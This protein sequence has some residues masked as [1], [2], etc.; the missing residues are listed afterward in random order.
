M[1]NKWIKKYWWLFLLGFIL[2]IALAF[3]ITLTR[4]NPFSETILSFFNDWSIPL[5]AL[6]T[7]IL[8]AVAFWA[9]RENRLLREEDRLHDLHRFALDKVYLWIKRLPDF[10]FKMH[11]PHNILETYGLIEEVAS[12]RFQL[13]EVKKYANM[14]EEYFGDLFNITEESLNEYAKTIND[15]LDEIR[16]LPESEQE[17]IFL[18][19]SLAM[20][21][22]TE[23]R[24]INIS[25]NAI[26]KNIAD[27]R[28]QLKL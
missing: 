7:V 15:K 18:D 4:T 12:L 25:S 2:I 27:I 13:L 9:I 24:T 26:L 21:W 20:F 14:F 1:L 6:T 11:T 28:I 3:L 19:F 8:A 17:T 23:L 10:G 16:T 22:I 5:S